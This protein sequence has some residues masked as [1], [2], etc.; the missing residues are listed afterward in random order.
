V[1]LDKCGKR[2]SNA[3]FSFTYGQ[4]KR[5]INPKVFELLSSGV[6]IRRTAKLLRVNQ[7]TIA[8]K[9]LFLAKRSRR[10]QKQFREKLNK[11]KVE[12][13]QFDDLITIEHSKLKPLS[14]SIAIETYSRKILA[15]E[16]SQIPAFGHL[17]KLSRKKYG[18]RKSF[19]QEGLNRLFQTLQECVS[20][21]ASFKSDE[22][23]LYAPSLKKYFPNARH[24]QFKGGR[25]CVAGQGELKKLHYDPLF[26]LNHTCAMLRA[27]I[28]RLIRKTWCTSKLRARLCDHLDIYT[29]FHN[30]ELTFNTT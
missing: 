14:V 8:R 3:T 10:R 22:H 9:L 27:N 2:F 26:S 1:G 24:I 20:E 23:T 16:V 4:R 28:N 25:G 11:R 29:D 12:N 13:I 19:H 21:Q 17:A 15:I 7:K 5:R 30:R 6:S 18:Y